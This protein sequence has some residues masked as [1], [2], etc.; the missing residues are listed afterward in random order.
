M[1]EKK[2]YVAPTVT[3]H[4]SAVVQ[5]QGRGGRNLELIGFRGGRPLG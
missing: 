2:P 5:T 1:T 4:G 3:A